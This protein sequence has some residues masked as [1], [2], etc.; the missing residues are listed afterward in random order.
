MSKHAALSAEAVVQ[1]FRE[2]AGAAIS[3]V[4]AAVTRGESLSVEIARMG[5]QC[6][7]DLGVMI[8]GVGSDSAV[9]RNAEVARAR[10]REEERVLDHRLVQL[11]H[12]N[13][14]AAEQARSHAVRQLTALAG[15]EDQCRSTQRAVALLSGVSSETEA[16]GARAFAATDAAGAATDRLRA[17]TR[18]QGGA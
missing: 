9:A 17:L 1:P 7:T 16:V 15:A 6:E 8:A 10:H 4:E 18:H 13:G 12:E 11:E 3:P 14:N 2:A 5:S